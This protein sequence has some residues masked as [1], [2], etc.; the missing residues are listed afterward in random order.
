MQ[1]NFNN[2]TSM[3]GWPITRDKIRSDA[4]LIFNSK[5]KAMMMTYKE[6]LALIP[7]QDNLSL[8]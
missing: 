1:E 4:K 3:G 2:I 6:S 5:F 8:P 7:W